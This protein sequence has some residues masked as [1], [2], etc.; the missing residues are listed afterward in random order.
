MNKS[1]KAAEDL[2]SISE[3]IESNVEEE[4]SPKKDK[5]AQPNP[6]NRFRT[7]E[8]TKETK[9]EP[10]GTRDVLKYPQRPGYVRRIVNDIEGRVQRFENAG[11]RVVQQEIIE[12]GDMR[13]GVASQLASPVL[14]PVGGGINAV[15]MEIPEDIYKEDQTKKQEQVDLSEESI[16]RTGVTATGNRPIGGAYGEVKIGLQ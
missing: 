13:V 4:K 3:E 14:K 12:G 6:L 8:V 16:R 7:D 15:L 11:W 5:T 1:E 2:R 9:R 10:I